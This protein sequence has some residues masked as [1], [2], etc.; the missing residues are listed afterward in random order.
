MFIYCNWEL[1][2]SAATAI[3]VTVGAGFDG[4]V[5]EGRVRSADGVEIVYTV[6]GSGDTTLVLIHGG[7]ADRRN[8]HMNNEQPIH[9]LE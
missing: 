5:V 1:L 2:V 8:F 9:V 7:L 3:A 6:V 4:D